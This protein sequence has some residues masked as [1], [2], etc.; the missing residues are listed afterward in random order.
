MNINNTIS[1]ENIGIEA[2]PYNEIIINLTFSLIFA[3]LMAISANSFIYLPF[4]PVPITMQVLTVLLSAI[5]LGSKWALASQFLYIFM[6]LAGLPVFSG[7]KSGAIALTGPTGGYIF[8]FLVAAFTAGYIYEN[9][10]Y[11]TVYTK[12][13]LFAGLISCI[14]GL[15]IIYSS[16]FI[17]LFGYFYNISGNQSISVFLIKTWK[18]GIEPFIIIDFL[19]ILIVL[20]ILNL[21]KLRRWKK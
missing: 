10:S 12:N 16:G 21:N 4:T 15:L 5:F 20:N 18:L 13:I 2:K 9:L 14:A 6:G 7:F 3:I 17:H 11:Q 19:K 8:G 1:I